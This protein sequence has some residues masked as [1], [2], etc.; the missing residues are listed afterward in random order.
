MYF[1]QSH[2]STSFVRR[3]LFFLIAQDFHPFFPVDVVPFSLLIHIVNSPARANLD[4]VCNR[5]RFISGAAPECK[6]AK[7][8]Q[9]SKYCR[10]ADHR[11]DPAFR[12][13]VIYLVAGNDVIA[14]HRPVIVGNIAVRNP[15]RSSGVFNFQL[16]FP[17]RRHFIISFISCAFSAG[18]SDRSAIIAR[19]ISAGIPESLPPFR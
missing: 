3:F 2:F 8:N 6:C 11:D 15:E 14:V 17:D 1:S 9:E 13:S 10:R 5:T 4:F 16:I 12:K 7:D 19:R 18:E